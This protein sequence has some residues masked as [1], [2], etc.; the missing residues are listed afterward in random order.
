MVQ[1]PLPNPL[2]L[3]VSII[4]PIIPPTI[5]PNP[6][7]ISIPL[8]VWNVGT[9]ILTLSAGEGIMTIVY[10]ATIREHIRLV[11]LGCVAGTGSAVLIDEIG[12]VWLFQCG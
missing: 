7:C 9:V 4:L 5:L 3:I 2:I 11:V 1:I 8:V 6:L 12:R 10:S